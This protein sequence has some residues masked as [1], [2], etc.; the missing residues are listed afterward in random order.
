M[1]FTE[2]FLQGLLKLDM[3]KPLRIP[4]FTTLGM[5][6]SPSTVWCVCALWPF[7]RRKI[8]YSSMWICPTSCILRTEHSSVRQSQPRPFTV[9][10]SAACELRVLLHK[11][12]M[13]KPVCIILP[14]RTSQADPQNSFL[15]E[16]TF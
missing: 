16:Q 11:R 7:R 5:S 6:S 14:W 15:Y 4:L 12:T 9:F 10:T 2:P 1:S 8:A 3:P 13:H